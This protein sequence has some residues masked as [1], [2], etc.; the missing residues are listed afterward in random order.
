[1]RAYCR[2]IILQKD[3]KYETLSIIIERIKKSF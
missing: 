1:M 2:E 3:E